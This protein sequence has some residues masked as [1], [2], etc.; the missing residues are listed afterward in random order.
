MPVKLESSLDTKGLQRADVAMELLLFL[1]TLFTI[2][3][4]V[5]YA[6]DDNLY[7]GARA[8]SLPNSKL[9]FMTC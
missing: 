6:G 3:A 2:A 7:E 8:G 1:M 5:I 4:G 9:R